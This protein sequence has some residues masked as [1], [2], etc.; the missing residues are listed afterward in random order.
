MCHAAGCSDT[1]AA[2]AMLEANEWH[3]E[4]AV[5]CFFQ[6]SAGNLGVC[7]SQCCMHSVAR[8]ALTLFDPLLQ[9]EPLERGKSKAKFS[10]LR[11]QVPQ[12]NPAY[13]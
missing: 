12:L 9:T 5:N 10:R 4:R 11:G 8:F 7:A 3:L 6:E 2:E 13:L 1:S